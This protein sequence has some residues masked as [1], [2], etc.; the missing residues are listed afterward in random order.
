MPNTN[1]HLDLDFLL[2]RKELIKH[3]LQLLELAIM[4]IELN[5][6]FSSSELI[7]TSKTKVLLH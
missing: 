4:S 6:V 2:K 3:E 1:N 7:N 5:Q